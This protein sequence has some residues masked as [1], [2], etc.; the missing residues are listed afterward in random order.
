LPTMKHI[1]LTPPDKLSAAQ[2]AFEI[3]T[4]LAAAIVRPYKSDIDATE[5]KERQ[6]GL[7][8]SGHQ[9]VHTNLY[10]QRSFK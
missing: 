9:R 6:V 3:T 2:R 8:Y 5:A 7:D 10:Q 4:I 1:L